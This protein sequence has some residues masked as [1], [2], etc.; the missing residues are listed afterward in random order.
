MKRGI[1][2]PKKLRQILTK[3]LEN[4]CIFIGKGHNIRLAK[5]ISRCFNPKNE[6]ES[7]CMSL[8][9]ALQLGGYF[10][11]RATIL[12][13][14][15]TS[16]C[17]VV[18]TEDEFL[19]AVRRAMYGYNIACKAEERTGRMDSFHY[20]KWRDMTV[21]I[22]GT[23][24]R[25]LAQVLSITEPEFA[26]NFQCVTMGQCPVTFDVL[27]LVLKQPYT[28]YQIVDRDTGHRIDLTIDP[29][30][31]TKYFQSVKLKV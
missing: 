1:F 13:K 11:N 21:V 12:Y 30:L 6:P 7:E 25:E 17:N 10:D 27:N 3:L 14:Y 20:G 26:T 28:P 31:I 8:T 29:E 5:A 2:L 23:N 22:N 16:C 19:Q 9:T 4:N 24:K 18:M 15:L